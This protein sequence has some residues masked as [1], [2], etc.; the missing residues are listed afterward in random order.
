MA[1]FLSAAGTLATAAAI[2]YLIAWMGLLQLPESTMSSLGLYVLTMAAVCLVVNWR[3]RN[4]IGR[5][6][7]EVGT[8]AHD[9]GLL[10]EL[11]LRLE[12]EPF[13]SPYLAALR[14]ELDFKG[15]PASSFIAQLHFLVE[16]MDLRRNE[17]AKVVGALPL[18]NLHLSYA[19]EAWRRTSG[20]S[21]R[22]WLRVVGEM[23]AIASLATFADEHP[24]YAFPELAT[25]CP[26]FEGDALGHPLIE[27]TAS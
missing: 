26:T 24:D 4:R 22:G 23:E 3:F 6:A 16:L 17:I 21:I 19:V 18:V 9:L 8:A 11:L 15:Q 25:E 13:A 20:G 7:R 2:A 10:K 12:A 1:W 5:I 14:A 27:A